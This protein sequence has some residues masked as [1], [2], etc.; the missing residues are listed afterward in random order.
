MKRFLAVSVGVMVLS[1]AVGLNTQEVGAAQVDLSGVTPNWDKN[2]PSASRFTVLPAFASK[3]VRDNNTGLV[4]EQAPEATLRTWGSA[5]SFCLNK[6]IGNAR[7]WRLPSVAELAS[8]INPSSPSPFV[9]ATVFT[10]VLPENY[11]SATS[12]GVSPTDAWY[13]DLVFGGVGSTGKDN[14]NLHF[15]C[16]RG[17]MNADVY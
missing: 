12:S 6:N 13:M 15:W 9:P 17:G 11:W 14:P 16:V 7:G 10:G 8:L 1:A 4:W 5:S 3:A 2:L